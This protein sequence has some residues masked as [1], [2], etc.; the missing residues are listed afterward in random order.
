MLSTI[1][2]S[3]IQSL[4]SG[5]DVSMK[6]EL[7]Q[8]SSA[9]CFPFILTNG[10]HRT[11]FSTLECWTAFIYWHFTPE[12]VYL[13]MYA[14]TLQCFRAPHLWCLIFLC[15]CLSK[16]LSWPCH[17]QLSMWTCQLVTIFIHF[18]FCPVGYYVT[19]LSWPKN[20]K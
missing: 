3:L 8:H 7:L 6:D 4:V 13:F 15:T 9:K 11:A 19:T 5:T 17:L 10:H 1:S 16:P 2:H 12:I 20:R 14:V 18:V